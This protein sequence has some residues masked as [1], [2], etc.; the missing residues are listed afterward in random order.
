MNTKILAVAI[1]SIMVCAGV[2]ATVVLMNQGG[3]SVK[4]IDVNLEI[5]GNADK[6]DRITDADA[7]LID[8]YVKAVNDNNADEKALIESTM[9]T[10]FA[11]ANRDGKIDSADSKQVRDIV[12]GKASHIWLLDGSGVERKVKTDIKRIG[13][14]YYANTELCLILGLADKICAVDNAPYLYRNF[15]FTEAQQKNITNMV[16]CSKPDYQLLNTLN[17]DTY[18]VFSEA[19]D[20][21]VKKDKI[22]GCDVLYMGLY[23]PDLTNTQKSSFVQGVLKSGYIFGKVTAAEKYV[24]W[25][26]DYRDKMLKIANGISDNNKPFVCMSNYSTGQYFHD[27]SQTVSVYK[28]ND[29]L[30]QAVTLA[31]GRNVFNTLPQT[32]LMKP[33]NYAATVKID[34]LLND[35]PNMHID[36][37]FLHMVKYTYSAATLATTP[38][39]GY[40]ID[41]RSE[42]KA[43]YN[44][45]KSQ[46]LIKDEKISLIAGDFRNGC[47]GGILLAAYMGNII[48]HD[49]YSSLDPVKIHNEYVNWLGVKNYDIA[50]KG[51][52]VESGS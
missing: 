3:S 39:H 43:A 52:F 34:T 2:G 46:S 51:V 6:D 4:A 12:S 38:S 11:D 19:A 13:C 28:P 29:P 42:I 15:Y 18:L 47:T 24:N 25:L 50:K 9:S 40:L 32:A 21:D 26:I 8:R 22:V 35:D 27:A 23:N 14:E 10:R 37:F 45:A 20:Y 7:T 5:F 44:T 41:D 1:A 36:Y 33:S 16:N 31:G 30:G 17:M 49:L 48:N